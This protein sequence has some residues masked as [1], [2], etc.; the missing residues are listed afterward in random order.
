MKKKKRNTNIKN[1]VLYLFITLFIAVFAV[2]M[3][4][5]DA[6]EDN[7]PN[8]SRP[9]ND[10]A[11][12]N[13]SFSSGMD[14]H[15]PEASDFKTA[16]CLIVARGYYENAVSMMDKLGVKWAILG[17]KESLLNIREA[18]KVVLI[19]SGGLY[20]KENDLVFKHM[21]SQYVL[22]GGNVIVLGQQYGSHFDS[23][24]PLAQD[25]HLKS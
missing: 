17:E 18:P 25:Q 6:C 7:N 24:L 14:V 20:G 19:P 12:D 22:A 3:P 10:H 2:P 4:A 8:P 1:I 15:I 21:L 23:V 16:E 9:G 13:F 11:D 5:S